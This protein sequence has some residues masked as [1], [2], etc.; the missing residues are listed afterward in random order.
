MPSAY[1]EIGKDYD[2]TINPDGSITWKSHDIRILGDTWQWVNYKLEQDASTITFDSAGISFKLDKGTCDFKFLDYMTSQPIIPNYD[3]R[4]YKDGLPAPQSCTIDSIIENERGATVNITK[5]GVRTIIILD[6]ADGVEWFYDLDNRDG[7]A[8]TFMLEETCRG[9]SPDSISDGV[10][11]FGK[12]ILDTKNEQ[13]GTLKSVT[14]KT[15]NII[16]QYEKELADREKFLIDPI[17]TLAAQDRGYAF[18]ATGGGA[19]CPASSTQTLSINPIT[20]RP[21]SGVVERCY[22]GVLEFNVKSIPGGSTISSIVLESDISASSVIPTVGCDIVQISSYDLSATA[23]PTLWNEVTT[24]TA[25]LTAD[26]I[27]NVAAANRQTAALGATA[28]TDMITHLGTDDLFSFGMRIND[29]NTRPAGASIVGAGWANNEL[30]VTYTA[31]TPITDLAAS[32]VRGTAVDLT[33]S[34]P[35]TVDGTLVGY[36]VNYST[37][38]SEK[39]NTVYRN[40]TGST[41]TGISVFELTGQ[42][43]YSFRVGYW[44]SPGGKGNMSGNIVNVTTLVDPTESFTPGTFNFTAVGSDDRPIVFER[45]DIS[46]TALFLNIT[47]DTDWNLACNFHYKFANVNKTYTNI[48][49]TTIDSETDAVGFRFNDVDNEIIDVLCWDQYTNASGRYLITQTAFPFLQNILDFRD[50]EF[51][52]QGMFGAVDMITLVAVIIGMVGFNRANESVGGIFLLF[53]MGALAYF[54]IISWPAVMTAGLVLALIVVI[55]ST[56]KD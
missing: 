30:I 14:S 56:R 55:G 29:Y 41:S 47:V 12:Y 10:L 11:R 3:I 13:H 2:T 5:D 19:A 43:E 26:P 53:I 8:T 22:V 39:V 7:K 35:T 9:C 49:N 33:W 45:N 25:Y 54:E 6:M 18:T 27:C 23:H 51:G 50:G 16:I 28:I 52:T 4:V 31:S 38:Q 20:R 48:A 34:A 37:P 24:G 17:V 36:Q 46:D 15:G 21:Q 42:T 1:A 44:V 40:D 32:D